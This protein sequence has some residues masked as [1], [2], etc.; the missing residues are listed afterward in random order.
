MRLHHHPELLVR[1]VDG[2]FERRRD[3]AVL[4]FAETLDEA[5]GVAHRLLA[6]G[7]PGVVDEDVHPPEALDDLLE[8]VIDLRRVGDVDFERQR[9]VL[10]QPG[11]ECRGVGADVEDDDASALLVEAAADPLP[12]P[13][14]PPVTIATRSFSL[15]RSP[16]PFH[17]PSGRAPTR[18]AAPRPRPQP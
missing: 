2:R 14:P 10:Q 11:G 7:D 5:L 13:D 12:D 1:D 9:F 16:P 15:I 8:G 4:R 6:A 3:L 18:L 17:R